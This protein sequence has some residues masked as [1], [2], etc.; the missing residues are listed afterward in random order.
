MNIKGFSLLLSF[1]AL[2]PPGFELQAASSASTLRPCQS[3]SAKTYPTVGVVER[4]DPA[5]DLL[6]PKDAQIELLADGFSWAEGPVWV[7]NG[8]YLLFSDIPKN[9]VFKWREAEGITEFLKPSGYTGDIARG[10]EAGSNGLTLD[11]HG[12]L[13]LCQH[14]DRQVARREKSGQVTVLAQFYQYLRFNSPNDLVYKS[15]GDLYFTDPPYGLL[16]QNTD[17][18]KELP[19]NG[20]YRLRKS[21][22][23]ELLVRD[24]TF[25]NG[26]AF[27]PDEKTLYVAVSDPR[28]AVWMAYAV[29]E[30]GTVGDGQVL[31]DV[32]SLVPTRKG[33]P[34]GL[35]VDR[36]GNLFAT[37][38]GGVLVIA[39][40]GRH[41]GTI[42]TGEPT[43]NCGW[44][45][46]GS[47]LYITANDKLCRIRTST[48]GKMP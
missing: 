44:G 32:T 10:G 28:R 27:S 8:S 41:L 38:P 48:R 39:P 36:S 7:R 29:R 18:A 23:V 34:D 17:P 46:N 31:M 42:N 37:G 26:I 12:R 5:L 20:V 3:A 47:V 16:Q 1:L 9:T 33:L 22:Q 45:G 19:F 21:G 24:L 4:L 40:D 13:I 2:L 25:P 14:G 43:A 6:L 11:S 15:N 30:D 35:K